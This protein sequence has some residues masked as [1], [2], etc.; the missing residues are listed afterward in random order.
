[1]ESARYIYL[2]HGNWIHALLND[3]IYIVLYFVFIFGTLLIG[4]FQTKKSLTFLPAK[5]HIFLISGIIVGFIL[6]SF[7]IQQTGGSNSSQFLITDMIIMS[8]YTA[9]TMSYWSEKL[10][11]RKTLVL[12]LSLI[13]ILLTIPRVLYENY[14]SLWNINHQIGEIVDPDE[15]AAIQYLKTQTPENSVILQNNLDGCEYLAF[16]AQRRLYYCRD[17]SPERQRVKCDR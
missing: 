3:L 12:L 16:L 6:G 17:G 13:I 10:H 9:M 11:K 8:I 7:F 5:L 4:L 2:A 14:Q 1:M 15:L